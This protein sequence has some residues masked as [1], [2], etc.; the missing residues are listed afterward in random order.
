MQFTEPAAHFCGQQQG[1]GRARGEA[2]GEGEG[3]HLKPFHHVSTLQRPTP[4][5]PLEPMPAELISG[6][7]V[8]GAA[9]RLR[10]DCRQEPGQ[11]AA[12]GRAAAPS[13]ALSML[14]EAW[15]GEAACQTPRLFRQSLLARRI[16]VLAERF[17]SQAAHIL[18]ALAAVHPRTLGLRCGECSI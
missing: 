10:G 15:E 1:R 2:E 4:P 12:L 14:G 3:C 9:C 16:C 7:E 5:T 17:S 8:G 18:P 11:N 13:W 6:E